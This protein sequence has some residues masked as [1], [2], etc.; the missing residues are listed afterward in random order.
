MLATSIRDVFS[1][2]RSHLENHADRLRCF[3][4]YEF[5]AEGWLKAEWVA[6]L[7]GMKRRGE[8]AGVDRE[9]VASGQRKIDLAVTLKGGR[10]WIELK[11]WLIG[12]QKGQ[13]WG[14]GAYI[15]DLDSEFMKFR[16]VK[17]GTRAWVAILCTS[18]PGDA[19]WA[20]A[21]RSFNISNSPWS[22]KALE[23]P[24]L[25]PSEYFLGVVQAKGF[26]A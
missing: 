4:D 17:A 24:S 3:R 7:D 18:N 2:F 22:L 10:H 13:T 8:I 11:H 1:T 25:Y 16:A 6:L 14:P 5:Q 12:V 23:K 20:S 21:L 9:V 26:E 19:A 15:D